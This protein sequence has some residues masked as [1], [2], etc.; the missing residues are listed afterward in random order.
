ME[1]EQRAATGDVIRLVGVSPERTLTDGA[2]FTPQAA[3]LRERQ[4]ESPF[5]VPTQPARTVF[6]SNAPKS[7]GRHPLP[8]ESALPVVG[9]LDL[10]K[11]RRQD[12]QASPTIRKLF[13]SNEFKI[14]REQVAAVWLHDIEPDPTVQIDVE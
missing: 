8:R 9:K 14:K 7:N 2:T 12:S 5:K 3:P 1:G 6:R 10:S 11:E 13:T 4:A